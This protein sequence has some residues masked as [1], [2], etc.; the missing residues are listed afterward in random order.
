LGGRPLALARARAETFEKIAQEKGVLAPLDLR[1]LDPACG[2]GTFL[3]LAIGRLRSY[4]EEHWVDKGVALKRIVKN[5]VGFDLNPLAVIASRANYLIALGDML[6]EKG[7]EPIEIPVY[8]ADSI[9]VERRQ[10]L[11]GAT[12]ILK[13][14]V[15]EFSIPTS[16]VEKGL[17]AKT[18]TLSARA[19][20]NG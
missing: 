2:S 14:A 5:V 4:V 1:L 9:L 6:R 10:T 20:K 18:L 13:T 19:R 11:A 12:Y 8:L 15:G 3:V 7:G 17:L 16:V